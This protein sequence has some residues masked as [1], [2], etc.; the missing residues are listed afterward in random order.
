MRGF[1]DASGT[2]GPIMSVAAWVGRVEKWGT[3]DDVWRAR[4]SDAG[5]KKFHM[6]EY[7]AR[8][9]EYREWSEKKRRSV[10]NWLLGLTEGTIIFGHSLSIDLNE[11]TSIWPDFPP[12]VYCAS[13]LI[14]AIAHRLEGMGITD[15]IFYVYDDGDLDSVDFKDAMSDIAALGE[16]Y[17]DMFRV[18]TIAPGSGTLW[19]GLDAADYLAWTGSHDP[20]YYRSRVHRFADF[21]DLRGGILKKALDA[22]DPL[23]DPR[24]LDD[25]PELAKIQDKWIQREVE[26][27][28]KEAR[29][30]KGRKKR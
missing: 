6:T 16:R 22:T 26:R 25:F 4:R 24:A 20:G 30:K 14:S 23:R 10:V 7:V 5:I 15:R 8:D 3:F 1:I 13:Q 21:W 17:R 19:P 9:G 12:Y 27:Q 18:H 2:G 11:Y 28:R 29:R